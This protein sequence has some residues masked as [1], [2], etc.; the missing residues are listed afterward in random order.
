MAFSATQWRDLLDDY[1]GSQAGTR[2]W[3]VL[4][5][6][7]RIGEYFNYFQQNNYAFAKQHFYI[8]AGT[9]ANPL[10]A[11]NYAAYYLTMY[12]LTYYA[13]SFFNNFFQSFNLFNNTFA[14]PVPGLFVGAYQYSGFWFTGPANTYYSVGFGTNYYVTSTNYAAYIIPASYSPNTFTNFSPWGAGP[15][16]AG[17]NVAIGRGPGGSPASGYPYQYLVT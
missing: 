14:S 3:S 1:S 12:A 2:S 5:R 15:Y 16:S 11:R 10:N 13:T 4:G 6:A 7:T 17:S 9:G 8:F